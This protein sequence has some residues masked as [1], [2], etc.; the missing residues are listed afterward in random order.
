MERVKTNI[1]KIING[2]N[3]ELYVVQMYIRLKKILSAV[4]CWHQRIKYI[5]TENFVIL[6]GGDL[7]F[8]QFS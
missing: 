1:D 3:R 7:H 8:S 2:K 4:G 5:P 6:K